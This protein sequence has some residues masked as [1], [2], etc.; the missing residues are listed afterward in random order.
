MT[1]GAASSETL[2]A[3]EV[4]GSYCLHISRVSG[5]TDAYEMAVTLQDAARL[6]ASG[7]GSLWL[8]RAGRCWKGQPFRAQ[9]CTQRR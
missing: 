5:R 4:C 8:V 2:P 7:Y 1:S 6:W 3:W 9:W